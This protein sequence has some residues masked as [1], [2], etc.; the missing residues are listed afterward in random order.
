MQI[1][2]INFV[3]VLQKPCCARGKKSQAVCQTTA[4]LPPTAESPVVEF[5]C[6]TFV[7]KG[8][9]KTHVKVLTTPRPEPAHGISFKDETQV[10]SRLLAGELRATGAHESCSAL[11]AGIQPGQK[12]RDI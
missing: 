12:I 9:V 8:S 11:K 2:P 7:P 4:S 10:E 5:A 3:E 6:C 1:G